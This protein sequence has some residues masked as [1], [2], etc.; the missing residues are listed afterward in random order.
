L[1]RSSTRRCVVSKVTL[2]PLSSSSPSA[3]FLRFLTSRS[4][5]L[6]SPLTSLS[7]LNHRRKPIPSSLIA[8]IAPSPFHLTHSTSPS[9][10]STTPCV[11]TT[12]TAG[13]TTT[14]SRPLTRSPLLARSPFLQAVLSLPASP[15]SSGRLASRHSPSASSWH[16]E[17]RDWSRPT[18]F[19]SSRRTIRTTASSSTRRI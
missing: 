16:T 5:A 1:V 2:P 8:L 9:P 7:L 6:L 11:A 13:F 10:A 3:H 19:S 18:T 17:E 14:P 12:K 4:F 15:T